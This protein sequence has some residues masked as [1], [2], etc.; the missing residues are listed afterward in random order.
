MPLTFV[1][2]IFWL[3]WMRLQRYRHRA[4]QSE[5]QAALDRELAI[6]PS[7]SKGSLRDLEDS[8]KG[9]KED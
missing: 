4:R 5:G 3:A 6:P 2:I 7:F 9:V 8:E 1:T